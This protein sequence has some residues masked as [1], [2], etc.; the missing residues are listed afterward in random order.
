LALSF[1][2]DG[3]STT[4]LSATTAVRAWHLSLI[5]RVAQAVR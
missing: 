4:P 2:C 3:E 5:T 1:G